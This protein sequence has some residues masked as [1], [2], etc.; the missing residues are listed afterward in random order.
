[1]DNNDGRQ[2]T[3]T[4]SR[5]THD[6]NATLFQTPIAVEGM[7]PSIGQE[8]AQP[9]NMCHDFSYE[10]SVTFPP[11]HVGE[12]VG[13][14]L[15]LQHSENE[16]R[17]L[18]E[19]CLQRDKAWSAAGNVHDCDNELR[20]RLLLLRKSP[21]AA[22]L[23]AVVS[24]NEFKDNVARKITSHLPP[25]QIDKT[26]KLSQKLLDLPSVSP[27][28]ILK[29]AAKLKTSKGCGLDG[30]SV[31]LSRFFGSQKSLSTV[32]PPSSTHHSP[33]VNFQVSGKKQE[34]S[35]FISQEIKKMWTTIDQYQS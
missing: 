19:D 30:I 10:D 1:M 13:P 5:T 3:F 35:Q 6:T 4:A 18:L 27:R 34:L 11:F 32:F 21:D 28:M 15:F 26:V 12:R 31:K 22:T 9:L 8:E 29:I 2:E 17:N 33:A 14:S 7:L 23:E 16:S 25:S 20:N 24:C